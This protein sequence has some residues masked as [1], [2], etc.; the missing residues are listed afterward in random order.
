MAKQTGI[1]E[2]SIRTCLENLKATNELTI[3]TT[4]QFSVITI[5]NYEK[6][7]IK[8]DEATSKP[9]TSD[10]QPTTSKNNKE[11]IYREFE[12]LSITNDEV[13]KL[14]DLGYSLALID[15]KIDEVLNFKGNS[16]YNSLYLTT[17]NWLKREHPNG[18]PQQKHPLSISHNDPVN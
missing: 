9:P 2:R 17:L 16:K 7:Q 12:H 1:S 10:Q 3:K 8:G 15:G 14:M 18:P 13:N 4:N 11:S 5:V 6:Y